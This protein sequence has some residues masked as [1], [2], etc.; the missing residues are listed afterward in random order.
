MI[1][2]KLLDLKWNSENCGITSIYK[3]ILEIESNK[4]EFEVTHSS[5][6]GW[7]V[8]KRKSNTERISV[9]NLEDVV[10]VLFL[11]M[12]YLNESDKQDLRRVFKII[13]EEKKNL[14]EEGKRFT[15]ETK[16]VHRNEPTY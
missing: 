4:Q 5:E 11:F 7:F 16:I 13:Q 1:K 6:A 14:H 10:R 2:C 8:K 9:V 15:W 12:N 3:V